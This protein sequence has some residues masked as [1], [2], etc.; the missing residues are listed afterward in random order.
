MKHPIKFILLS[1]GLLAFA[2]CKQQSAGGFET[3]PVSGIKYHFIKQATTG[4]QKPATED[5]AEISMVIRNAKDSVIF[6]SGNRNGVQDSIRTLNVHIKQSF[7]GCLADGLML[8][9]V[10]DSASFQIN[11]DSMFH[12]TFGASNLPPHVQAGTYLTANVKLLKIRNQEQGK[13]EREK[14]IQEREALMEKHKAEEPATIEAYLKANKLIVKP[15]SNGMYI[16]KDK[17]GTGK[18]VNESDS[19]E[20][21]FTGRLLDGTIVDQSNHG[22]ERTSYFVAF[23][24]ESSLQGVEDMLAKMKE[25]EEVTVLFPSSLAYGKHQKGILIEPYTPLLFDIKVVKVKP[26]K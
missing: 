15:E 12:K 24:K 25:G 10:G 9:S 1:A 7:K 26:G 23:K 4:G 5:Y 22:P 11:A 14:R 3:D 21:E 8:M 16:L 2:A 18:G 19:V 20:V 6:N 17:K 13:A